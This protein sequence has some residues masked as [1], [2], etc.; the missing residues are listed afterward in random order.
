MSRALLAKREI[1]SPNLDGLLSALVLVPGS[2]SR[3]RFYPLF[4]DTD[5]SLVR[6]RAARLSGI[7]RHLASR[8]EPK[9][10]ILEQ[11]ALDGDRWL[12][13]YRMPIVGLSRTAILDPLEQAIVRYA[14]DRA[15]VGAMLPLSD[16]HRRLVESALRKLGDGL[17]LP[18]QLE[19]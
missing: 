6:K 5:A 18:G 12:L 15:G 17:A 13:R 1:A 11:R 8:A 16:E 10:V 2:Y 7:V 9:A 14:L 19:D 3:N 4:T